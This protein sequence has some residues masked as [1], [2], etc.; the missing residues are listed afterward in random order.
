LTA[1]L[2]GTVYFGVAT[3]S[4][5]AGRA[6]LAQFRDLTDVLNA[7]T[8]G[9]LPAAFEPL[10]P[11][12]RRTGLVIS[13][14]M[15]HPTNRI[16]GRNLEFVELF[17]STPMDEPLAGFRLSGAIDFQ[18]SPGTILKAGAFLVIARAPADIQT[19]YGIAN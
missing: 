14:I 16:D 11:S 5:N 2:P 12:T 8:T 6:T 3:A 4:H 18:F 10:G 13:E 9:T 15:Y 19:V 1:T 7:T 17:N